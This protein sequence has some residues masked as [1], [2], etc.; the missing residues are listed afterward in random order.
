[1][2]NSHMPPA[3]QLF[4]QVAS[5]ALRG[6]AQTIVATLSQ[7]DLPVAG[8]TISAR[9]RLLIEAANTGA[10]QLAQLIE[11]LET[12][13]K[14]ADG[15]LTPAPRPLPLGPL[16][17]EA[18]ERAQSPHAPAAPRAIQ[19]SVASGLTDAYGSAFLASRALAALIENALRFSPAD[20]PVAVEAQRRGERVA[21]RVRDGGPGVAADALE[22]LF[23]P[24]T[25]GAAPLE[26]VGVGLGVGLGLAVA[27]ACAE[28][29]GGV[30]WLERDGDGASFILELPLPPFAPDGSDG[31]DALDTPESR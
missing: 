15:A 11:D 20:A 22:R 28:A 24:L 30:L 26:H 14:R 17:A 7:L 2:S 16:I 21:I 31:S 6:V 29:Q 3:R 9:Q 27:R 25:I 12:L 19:V 10:T 1:M 4:S 5:H 8:E 18:I 13:M 23:E